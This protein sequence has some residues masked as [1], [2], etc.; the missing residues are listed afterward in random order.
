[1]ILKHGYGFNIAMAR[2]VALLI[3]ELYIDRQCTKN[4]KA[5]Y[6]IEC[7]AYLITY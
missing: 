1:M 7:M 6:L 3:N 2:I 4:I 5:V